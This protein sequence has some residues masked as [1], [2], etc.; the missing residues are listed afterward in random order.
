METTNPV[1]L[2]VVDCRNT[3]MAQLPDTLQKT[4]RAEGIDTWIELYPTKL[5]VFESG[6]HMYVKSPDPTE[7][8]RSLNQWLNTCKATFLLFIPY[9]TGSLK[10][11]TEVFRNECK[12]DFWLPVKNSDPGNFV[13]KPLLCDLIIPKDCLFFG[14]SNK[15]FHQ[16]EGISPELSGYLETTDML[17]KAKRASLVI[18]GFPAMLSDRG[19][20]YNNHFLN[21]RNTLLLYTWHLPLILFAV[22]LFLRSWL[23]LF[24]SMLHF[25]LCTPKHSLA[26]HQSHAA[27]F[28]HFGK[29]WKMRRQ[30]R[31]DN[32]ALTITD[33]YR[34]GLLIP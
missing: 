34:A 31:N 14:I 24:N 23:D 19:V 28:F 11:M 6:K 20:T 8:I 4:F 5:R 33:V 32:P 21:Y 13:L 30:F 17:W 22:L 26:I 7:N 16:L 18:C 10:S 27:Y 12:P 3:D 29:W 2:A 25:I 15:A 9:H 1:F